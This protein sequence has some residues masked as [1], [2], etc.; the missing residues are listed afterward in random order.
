MKVSLG[1]HEG[2]IRISLGSHQELQG[3]LVAITCAMAASVSSRTEGTSFHP[4]EPSATR[5]APSG[6]SIG[7]S[8][9]VRP[10]GKGRGA[11]VSTCMQGG[12]CSAVEARL[13]DRM[14]KSHQWSSEVISGHQWSSVVVSPDAKEPRALPISPL[15]PQNQRPPPLPLHH[16]SADS[17][18]RGHSEAIREA[19]RAIRAIRQSGTIART[20]LHA[21]TRR[22]LGMQFGQSGQLGNQGP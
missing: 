1:S 12:G 21:A 17:P 6:T 11:V 8:A 16:H 14:R 13:S 19:I 7:R 18:A 3:Q 15:P 2:L 20:R 9:A 4:F 22:Q 10:V 5:H